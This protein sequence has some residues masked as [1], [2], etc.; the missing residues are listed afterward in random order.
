MKGKVSQKAAED[1]M[2]LVHDIVE[3]ECPRSYRQAK[4]MVVKTCMKNARQIH[5]CIDDCVVYYD[6]PCRPDYQYSKLK[7]CPRC[8]KKRF[9]PGTKTPRK[10]FEFIPMRDWVDSIFCR[11][12]LT[13]D[14]M[15]DGDRHIHG[16]RMDKT[17]T[18]ISDSPEWERVVHEDDPSF[19]REISQYSRFR[20]H[21]CQSVHYTYISVHYSYISVHFSPLI[22]ISVHV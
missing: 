12:D 5:A 21:F 2:K 22:R 6:S 13:F 14:F 8:E 18:D 3:P 17:W 20:K 9:V 1:T 11:P 10:V 4:L 15:R 16:G 19:G 7:K